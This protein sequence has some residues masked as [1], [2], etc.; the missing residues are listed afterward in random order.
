ME[1]FEKDRA[2]FAWFTSAW[3]DFTDCFHLLLPVLLVQAAAT[4][5]FF[6]LVHYYHSVIPAFAYMLLVILLTLPFLLVTTESEKG[7]V[8]EA[9]GAGENSL[10]FVAAGAGQHVGLGPAVSN[11]QLAR[12]DDHD[13]ARDHDLHRGGLRRSLRDQWKPPSDHDPPLRDCRGRHDP[14]RDAGH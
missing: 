11:T 2:S 13:L 3:Y 7:A 9:A 10:D 4:A 1:E 5:G 14:R 8:I 12:L 6:G